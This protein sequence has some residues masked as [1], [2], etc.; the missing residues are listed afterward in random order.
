MALESQVKRAVEIR[1]EHSRTPL[2]MLIYE[3]SLEGKDNG[4]TSYWAELIAWGKHRS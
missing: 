3:L 1:A 4:I 2:C